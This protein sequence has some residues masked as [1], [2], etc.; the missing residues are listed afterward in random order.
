MN[1]RPAYIVQS[2]DDFCFLRA[3]GD[4][5][6]DY[7][8]LFAAATPFDT[9]EAALEA[10]DDHCGGRGAVSRLWVPDHG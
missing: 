7:T 5:G 4:G 6:V 9:A 10:V 1:C 8:H 3:D 2:T